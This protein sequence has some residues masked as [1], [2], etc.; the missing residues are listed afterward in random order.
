MK[1]IVLLTRSA[2]INCL[3]RSGILHRKFREHRNF[4]LYVTIQG[5][6]IIRRF[7]YHAVL[8]SKKPAVY[9]VLIS[10]DEKG[11]AEA[12]RSK[13]CSISPTDNCPWGCGVSSA[14][15]ISRCRADARSK[16]CWCCSC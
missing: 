2:Y 13:V 5:Y 6:I 4:A 8:T 10:R 7:I 15:D 14:A 11:L 16:P 1:D 12:T 9:D 3:Q